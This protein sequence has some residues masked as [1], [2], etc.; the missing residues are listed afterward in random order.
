MENRVPACVHTALQFKFLIIIDVTLQIFALILTIHAIRSIVIWRRV[1]IFV[2]STFIITFVAYWLS[3]LF[4]EIISMDLLCYKYY[5]QNNNNGFYIVLF[6]EL[7]GCLFWLIPF[8]VWTGI[9]IYRV[10]FSF[11]KKSLLATLINVFI[12]VVIYIGAIIGFILFFSSYLDGIDSQFRGIGLYVLIIDAGVYILFECSMSVIYF[13]RLFELIILMGKQPSCVHHFSPQ[14]Y[15]LGKLSVY[16]ATLNL[17]S[18]LETTMDMT[19]QYN[20]EEIVESDYGRLS[21]AKAIHSVLRQNQIILL[22]TLSKSISINIVYHLILFV[23]ITGTIIMQ[24]GKDKNEKI[25]EDVNSLHLVMTIFF[26]ILALNNVLAIYLQY[27]FSNTIYNKLKCCIKLD[28][29]INHLLTSKAVKI[30]NDSMTNTLSKSAK[31]SMQKNI[32]KAF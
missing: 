10:S 16:P 14:Y 12:L 24:I 21:G 30:L 7:G 27:T 17:S 28:G 11:H 6:M 20:D 18:T 8:V 31:H 15:N 19:A 22:Q 1:T 2:R 13:I 9:I 4:G 25:F 3:V 5:N 29:I 23:P 32:V 26:N